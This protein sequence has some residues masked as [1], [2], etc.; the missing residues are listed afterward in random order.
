M[1]QRIQSLYLLASSGLMFSMFFRPLMRDLDGNVLLKFTQ[2]W[3][4][5]IF[6]IVTFILSFFC[7]FLYRRRISQLRAV[8]LQFLLYSQLLQEFLYLWH[9]ERFLRMR[10]WYSL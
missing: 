2:Y 3:P 1:I 4:F 10:H 6:T 5:L 9:S 8:Y 7:I